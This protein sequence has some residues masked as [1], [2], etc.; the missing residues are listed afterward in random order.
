MYEYKL[1]QKGLKH[2]ILLPNDEGWM[3]DGLR[4]DAFQLDLAPRHH[5]D[6]LVAVYANFRH[7][8]KRLPSVIPCKKESVHNAQFGWSSY[9]FYFWGM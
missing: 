1:C 4:D 7:C 2:E 9:H 6:L 8:K 5:V 3:L